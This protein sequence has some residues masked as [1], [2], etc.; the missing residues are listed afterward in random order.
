[1]KSKLLKYLQSQIKSSLQF[2]G[3]KKTITYFR[4]F[5]EPPKK[6][7]SGS[8]WEPRVIS[9]VF[10]FLHLGRFLPISVRFSSSFSSFPIFLFIISFYCSWFLIPPYFPPYWLV[11]HLS[12]IFSLSFPSVICCSPYETPPLVSAYC[13]T[14][15]GASF[16]YTHQYYKWLCTPVFKYIFRVPPLL[17]GGFRAS[18][19]NI[20]SHD[21]TIVMSGQ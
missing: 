6:T 17:A 8:V 15:I 4:S 14:H 19:I 5:N 16:Y 10:L 18:I 7:E 3:E 11:S 9:F 13:L 2:P 20:S 1:M 21:Q 12:V